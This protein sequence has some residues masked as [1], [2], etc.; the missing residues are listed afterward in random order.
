MDANRALVAELLGKNRNVAPNSKDKL[1]HWSDRKVC[2][3]FLCGLC[4][5]TLF[6]NTKQDLGPCRFEHDQGLKTDYE[7]SSKYKKMGYEEDWI[8][9]LERLVKEIDWQIQKAKQRIKEQ[10]TLQLSETGVDQ[11]KVRDVTNQIDELLE[12]VE[13][14]GNEGKIDEVESLMRSVDL[15]KKQKEA[16]LNA[17]GAT[18]VVGKQME[19]CDICSATL[20]VGDIQARVDA[21]LQGK[22]H[23]GF[24]LIRKTIKDLKEK[25]IEEANSKKDE[26]DLKTESKREPRRSPE[27]HSRSHKDVSKNKEREKEKEKE[28][29]HRD[30]D[31]DRDRDRN[32]NQTRHRDRERDRGADRARYKHSSSHRSSR[33]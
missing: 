12:K 4:P 27:N 17:S 2:K 26:R 15:L 32:R 19:V 28:R 29:S 9:G 31:R 10:E 13:R 3:P 14:L 6:T 1:A 16:I 11:E 18:A 30:R 21:H 8:A 25:I 23:V 5:H 20:V 22:Q 33:H 7:K 24:L